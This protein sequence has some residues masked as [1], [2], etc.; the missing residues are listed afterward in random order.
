MTQISCLLAGSRLQAL[1]VVLWF[2]HFWN[3]IS[4]CTTSYF[5][6]HSLEV[7]VLIEVYWGLATEYK[8][9]SHISFYRKNKDVVKQ[10]GNI[11]NDLKLC[12]LVI[13]LNVVHLCLSV[14]DGFY[15]QLSWWCSGWHFPS[16]TVVPPFPEYIDLLFV[17]LGH[18]FMS[19]YADLSSKSS[20]VFRCIY[21][22]HTVHCWWH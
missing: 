1:V 19:G 13:V 14:F 9:S 4:L 8:K 20:T 2:K 7:F 16:Y 6:P 22:I 5:S 10:G 15:S 12:I 21:L 3:D 17:Y 11:F 18:L